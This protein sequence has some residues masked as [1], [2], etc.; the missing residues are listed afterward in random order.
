MWKY[1][2]GKFIADK[3]QGF[4]SLYLSNGESFI[5]IFKDGMVSGSGTFS[6]I[7]ESP[8]FGEWEC[9]R[10]KPPV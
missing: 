1:F 2:D 9:N 3:R 8:I 7:S 6:R 5:G 4:G 10:F